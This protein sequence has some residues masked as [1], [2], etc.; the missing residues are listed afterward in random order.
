MRLDPAIGAPAR[1]AMLGPMQRE[2]L[3][4]VVD[5]DADCRALLV[6]TLALAKVHAIGCASGEE[7]LAHAKKQV[8]TVVVTDLHM[9][10]GTD[11]VHLARAC[12]AMTPRP[13][14][15]AQTGD[16]RVGPETWG[17]FDGLLTKPTD[18]LEVAAVVVRVLRTRPTPPARWWDWLGGR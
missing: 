8:P 7:A 15:L 3:V 18:P 5:D 4:L 6:E 12:A 9:P 10:P 14:V 1:G 2:P 17:A 11:G 16:A 13:F